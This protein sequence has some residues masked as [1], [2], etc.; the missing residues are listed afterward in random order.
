[1]DDKGTNLKAVSE[2]CR[3]GRAA[4][5]LGAV[6]LGLGGAA[7]ASCSLSERPL[8]VVLVSVDTLRAD[9]L[10][11][12][13]YTARATSPRIDA[14]AEEALVFEAHVAAAPWTTPSHLSLLTGLTPTGHGVTC[15]DRSLREALQGERPIP[16]LPEAVTT[17]AEALAERGWATAAFTGGATLDPRIGFHQGFGDYDTTMVKLDPAKVDRVLGWIDAHDEGPFFLFWHTFE[18]H[19]PYLG[20]DFL[21][22][23][24]PP[25]RARALAERLEAIPE[26]NG[27]KAVRAAKRVMRLHGAYDPE[28]TRAL[29]D[30]GIRSFDRW[31]GRFVDGLRD[32]GLLDRTLLVLT[33]DHGE[34]LGE[35]GRPAPFGDGFYNVH[36]HTLY[37]E[38]VH[39]PLIIRGPG[40][41]GGRRITPVTASIDVMPTILDVL[42]VPAP[43]PVQGRS[44][45]PLWE[46][47]GEWTPRGALSESLSEGE[48]MKS[49]RTDRYKYVLTIDAASVAENGRSYVPPDAEPA[50]YDLLEDPLE[51][52]DLLARPTTDEQTRRAAALCAELRDR[53]TTVG[54]PEE[55]TLSPEARE[56]LEA[57]GYLQ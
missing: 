43:A 17:L 16:R 6:V 10:G 15:S 42:G 2:R 29:Y 54:R 20:T 44:L 46:S 23:V 40:L 9:H 4:L 38:L 22:D 32:R 13:G 12:Y 3:P 37:E 51:R 30:G 50:L 28:V 11:T 48:E 41:P 39:V 33:S 56:G 55:G 53:L 36:G 7:A 45:R 35:E 57:L 49:L 1:M 34:Q 47:P 14:L 5:R 21:A 52:S 27:W 19:A 8:N 25:E 24:L 31:L 26:R 18:V